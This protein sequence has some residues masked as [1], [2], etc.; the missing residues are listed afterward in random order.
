MTN[1]E[2]W[3]RFAQP[4]LVFGIQLKYCIKPAFLE[5]G[6]TLDA[7]FLIDPGNLFL[8]PGDGFDRTTPKT[9][10]A[11]GT[12]IRIDFKFQK[13]SAT[14]GRTSFF[15]YVGFIFVSKVTQS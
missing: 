3:I 6:H 12:H 13:R 5:T 8:F 4:I 11:F 9:Q 7:F 10:P 2:L 15:N 1:D 14:F